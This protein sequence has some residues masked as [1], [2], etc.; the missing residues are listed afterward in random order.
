VKKSNGKKVKK[1]K[2]LIFFY[3][4]YEQIRLHEQYSQ[5]TIHI[6][7]LLLQLFNHLSKKGI[8]NLTLILNSEKM[9]TSRSV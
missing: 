6:P 9:R 8:N 3:E 1:K 2:T 7:H 4:E 5:Q